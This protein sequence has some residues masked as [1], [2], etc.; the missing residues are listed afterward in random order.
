M[1]STPLND[2]HTA[3]RLKSLELTKRD[4]NSLSG[5]FIYWG[6]A[7]FALAHI[8]FNT[9]GTLSELWVPAIHFDGFALIWS[10]MVPMSS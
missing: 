6:G 2:Q 7:L 5:R 4:E 10:L 3:E 1:T 9:L 8:Y